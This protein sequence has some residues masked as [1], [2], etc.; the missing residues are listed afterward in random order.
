LNR[1]SI[2]SQKSPTPKS[3]FQ[4]DRD[5]FTPS[6]IEEIPRTEFFASK[7]SGDIFSVARAYY[8]AQDHKTTSIELRDCS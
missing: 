2:G 5:G 8:S 3:F 7:R 1:N 4:L 6:V